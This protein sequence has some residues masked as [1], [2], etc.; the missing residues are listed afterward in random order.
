MSAETL[1]FASRR[2]R[3]ARAQALLAERVAIEADP[4]WITGLLWLTTTGDQQ[5]SWSLE[6]QGGKGLFTKEIE[7]AVLAGDADLAVH[8]AKDLPTEMPPGLDLAAFL[9]REDPRDVLILRSG[10][11][12][13]K[14]IATSS[15]RRR[16]Q[17]Q[18]LFPEASFSEIRGNVETRLGKIR[19]GEADATVLAA[20][21]LNRLGIRR[22]PGCDFRPLTVE[23]MIP[24]CGQAAIALQSRVEDVERFALLGCEKT[25]RAV[26]CER[27]FL[28]ALGG[29]C[30]TAFAGFCE[31]TTFH[32]F[33]EDFGR[34]TVQVPTF[35]EVKLG[36]FFASTFADWL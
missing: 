33:H 3:L 26:L 13:P 4:S 21:G 35:D 11:S 6:K 30:H 7:D 15:P 10:V 31:G 5:T 32:A 24:A 29:G 36:E 14:R 2:S 27:S 8:S 17:L 34:R 20:A 9:P 18:L 22:S 19:D 28:R 1:I 16:A 25:R 23:E 12:T